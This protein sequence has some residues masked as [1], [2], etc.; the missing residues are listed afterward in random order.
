MFVV[1]ATICALA[2]LSGDVIAFT[3]GDTQAARRVSIIELESGT[4]TP[5]GPGDHDGAPVWSPDGSGLAF[6]SARGDGLGIYVREYSAGTGR[7]LE[8][9]GDWNR[10]PV[11]SADGKYLAYTSG[12]GAESRIAVYELAS[13]R[14]E[15]WGGEQRGL[16]LPQ[17]AP[18]PRL[19]ISLVFPDGMAAFNALD[20]LHQASF[21]RGGV[22]AVALTPEGS[23]DIVI[24]TSLETYPFPEIALP[25]KGNYAEWNVRPHLRNKSVA[26]ESNDGGDREI[27]VATFEGSYDISNDPGPDWNP[28]WSPDGRWVAFESLRSG[29]RG[30]YRSQRETRRVEPVAVSADADTW[31]PAWS[32]DGRRIAFVS[33]RTG[34]IE[35][36]AVAIGAADPLQLT[37]LGSA[38][39][40][41]AWRPSVE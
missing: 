34:P 35:L 17:W 18:D 7:F 39:L 32:P 25:S 10:D 30:I 37:E 20:P 1:L 13:G 38:V 33:D 2:A 26:F 40:A 12:P 28:V 41:P 5:I 14:E 19:L 29:R 22:I 4:I 36:F 27:F 11:W 6:E 8:S 3:S 21:K 31:T 24:A 23:T 9:G 16:M 15:F